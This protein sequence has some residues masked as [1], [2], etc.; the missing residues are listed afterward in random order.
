MRYSPSGSHLAIGCKNGSLVIMAV[1]HD[2]GRYD[3]AGEQRGTARGISLGRGDEQPPGMPDG[4]ETGGRAYEEL[5]DDAEGESSPSYRP[6][7]ERRKVYRRIAHLKG[8]S[9]RVLHLDWTEDGRF[10]HTCG[11]DYHL[12]HWDILPPSSHRQEDGAARERGEGRD[13]CNSG[14]DED[15]DEAFAGESRP[16]IF[17]RAFLVRNE[18]WATW[19]STI[20]WPV[21]VSEHNTRTPTAVSVFRCRKVCMSV[22]C[23]KLASP[24][25]FWTRR[26]KKRRLSEAHHTRGNSLKGQLGLAHLTRDNFEDYRRSTGAPSASYILCQTVIVRKMS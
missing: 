10:V 1:E 2:D 25:A 16:R 8:H 11:Q 13:T 21:Q 15:E 19:S 9:S 4:M 22:Q 12:L 26:C 18:P 6:K 24:S 23:G 5:L 3:D 7:R 20:G 14:G 17:K